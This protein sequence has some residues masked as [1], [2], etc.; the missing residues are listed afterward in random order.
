MLAWNYVHERYVKHMGTRGGRL[1]EMI[2]FCNFQYPI[3]Q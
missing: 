2:Q 1:V 3:E